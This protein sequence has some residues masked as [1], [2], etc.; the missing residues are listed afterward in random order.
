MSAAKSKMGT[1]NETNKLELDSK[2]DKRV[3]S[4]MQERRRSTKWNF[5]WVIIALGMLAYMCMLIYRGDITTSYLFSYLLNPVKEVL[6]FSTGLFIKHVALLWA[7]LFIIEVI[8]SLTM[9]KPWTI[10]RP[11][12]LDEWLKKEIYELYAIEYWE[13]LPSWHFYNND[14]NERINKLWIKSY[15]FER[16]L[17]YSTVPLYLS[18][19]IWGSILL[20]YIWEIFFQGS[21]VAIFRFIW[22]TWVNGLILAY[23][24]YELI[25]SSSL[26]TTRKL[27]FNFEIATFILLLLSIFSLLTFQIDLTSI[28]C[29][30]PYQH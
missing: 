25:N 14:I 2:K 27:L 5:F 22:F 26:E 18:I 30:N 10:S 13:N 8:F 4:Y 28:S 7:L 23:M 12:T 11:N 20:N 9:S 29:A 3:S 6:A 1:K 21:W 17:T 19:I 15:F 24:V 16:F